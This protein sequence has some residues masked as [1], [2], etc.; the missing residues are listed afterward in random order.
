MCSRIGEGMLGLP[1]SYRQKGAVGRVGVLD[2][3]PTAAPE[4]L[5]P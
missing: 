4:S 1:D 5:R 3:N 2:L